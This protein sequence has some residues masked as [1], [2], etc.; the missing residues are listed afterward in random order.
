MRASYGSALVNKK[1]LGEQTVVRCSAVLLFLS[2]RIYM[3]MTDQL[4]RSL[5]RRN[6]HWGKCVASGPNR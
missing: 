6:E 3:L 5:Q 4:S 1:Q 2:N